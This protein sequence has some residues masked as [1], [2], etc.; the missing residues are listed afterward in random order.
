MLDCSSNTTPSKNLSSAAAKTTKSKKNLFMI[1]APPVPPVCRID[2]GNGG[3]VHSG[4]AGIKQL[5][6]IT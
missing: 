6:Q 2:R 1:L 3:A 4:T 5:N